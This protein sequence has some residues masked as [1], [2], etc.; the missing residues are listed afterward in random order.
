MQTRRRQVALLLMLFP[1]VLAAAPRGPYATQ[2]AREC[3]ALLSDA[4]RRPYGLGW[5]SVPLQSSVGRT[6]PRHVMLEP[7]GTPATALILL[8]S[9][10]LLNDDRYRQAA[11][12]CARGIAAAQSPQGKIPEHVIFGP[13]SSSARDPQAM[14]P[15]RSGTCASI[16]L[17][18]A[19]LDDPPEKPE[20]LQRSV[21]R[22]TQWL[23]KQATDEG[24]WPQAIPVPPDARPNGRFLRMDIPDSRDAT[25]ALL[26][27]ADV[28]HDPDVVKAA[29]RS[30]TR[31][32][33]LR[34][35]SIT[36]Q[37]SATPDDPNAP[38][39][40]IS[41][42]V[43][44]RTANLWS[45]AYRLNGTVD[46]DQPDFPAGAD[47]VA[48]RYS[49]Q[50][51]IG[52]YLFTGQQ[53]I[54]KTLDSTAVSIRNLRRADGSWRRLYGPEETA[55]TD[56]D[57]RPT[58]FGPPT[59]QPFL[60][61]GAFGLPGT[62]SQI[63]QLKSIGQQRYLNLLA[64]PQ[65]LRQRVMSMLCGLSDD[66]FATDQPVEPSEVKAYLDRHQADWRALGQP[67]P[68]DLS[69]RARRLWLLLLRARLEAM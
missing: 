54:G 9:G 60:G 20:V 30:V 21:Q 69:A 11:V 65:G 32:I 55:P 46:P 59:S 37:P 29:N 16:A 49:M 68:D 8:W 12:D 58:V 13:T 2:L 28:M 41:A 51:L 6:A 57:L 62:L 52:A 38:V 23:T 35:S 22:A 43:N 18:L 61:S 56:D 1:T 53:S 34:G 5:D 63:D 39:V 40:R 36:T 19:I 42:R 17:F 24:G 3:D 45:I 7:P 26:L 27:A 25:L 66:P 14:V 50:T 10:Q 31:M 44:P 48:C 67:M 33:T 15:D 4:V 64:G 47:M